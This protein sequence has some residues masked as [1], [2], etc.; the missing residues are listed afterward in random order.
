MTDDDAAPEAE[1][2]RLV[3]VIWIA[4]RLLGVYMT[5]VGASV[6]TED[7]VTMA[8]MASALGVESEGT[9]F[10]M[11]LTT[12]RFFGDAVYLASGLYLIFGGQWL[13]RNVFL[14]ARDET[15]DANG[16]DDTAPP[17]TEK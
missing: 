16:D 7:L 9:N 1:Y 2:T 3:P 11:E 12:P 17:L 6:M 14:P 13:I 4:L 10:L 15:A 8:S 5:I